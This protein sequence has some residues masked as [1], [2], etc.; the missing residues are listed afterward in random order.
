ML[1]RVAEEVANHTGVIWTNVISLRRE[2]AERLGYDSAVQWPALLRSKVQLL[3]ENY[4]I[5]SRNLKWYAAFHNEPYHPHVHLVVY[6]TTP[7]EGYLTTKGINA[8]RSAY[9]HDI[10]R[11]DFISIYEKTT[12][13]RDRLK[14]QA[15]KRVMEKRSGQVHSRGSSATLQLTV[16]LLYRSNS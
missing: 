10:L 2:D 1:S 12:K 14:E 8:M 4:K 13:Q 6:S 9:A 5:G 11:Q 15:E 3:C 7:S 16:S